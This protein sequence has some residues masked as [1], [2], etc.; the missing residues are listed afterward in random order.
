MATATWRDA[1][2]LS[3]AEEASDLEDEV[4]E[5]IR[6]EILQRLSR[7][8]YRFDFFQVVRLLELAFPGAPS[9]GETPDV[10]AERIRMRP[11]AALAFPPADI[12]RIVP[13][14]DPAAPVQLH[15]T[16]MGLYGVSSPLPEFFCETAATEQDETRALRAFLDL[17]NHR[18]YAFFY[19]AWKKYRPELFRAAEGLEGYVDVHARR[20]M[21]LSGLGTPRAAEQVPVPRHLLLTFASRLLPRARNAEGLEALLS[22]WL[23]LP[24]QVEE[25][26]PRWVAI[27]DRPRMGRSGMQLGRSS[28]I[29]RKIYDV[30]GKFRLHIGPMDRPQYL[31]LLPGGA[32]AGALAWLVRAYLPGYLDFDVELRLRS[33]A[34][35]P[36]R[37]GDRDGRLGLTATLGTPRTP[38]LARIVDYGRA[39]A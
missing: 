7:E 21:A 13:P 8:G 2:A 11:D 34:L 24:V 6:Q 3:P 30:M 38:L 14:A 9:P 4:R 36:T 19:R 31:A 16:F 33:A 37:L 1:G 15:L 12:R 23:E 32:L 22:G 5:R 10:G 17:F 18:L 29:G 27:R 39:A 20:F 28:T 26:V 25:N 35:P